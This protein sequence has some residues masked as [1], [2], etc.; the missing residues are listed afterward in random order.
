VK[1]ALLVT[2]KYPQL[3]TVKTRL[4]A[5][6]GEEAALELYECFVDDVLTAARLSGLPTTIFCAPSERLKDFPKRFASHF[7]YAAQHGRDLG[8]RMLQAF[9]HSFAGEAEAALLIG[10]DLPEMRAEVLQSAAQALQEHPAVIV[11]AGDGG[12]CLIGFRREQLV[13]EA[14]HGIPWSTEHV[15]DATLDAMAQKG[16]QPKILDPVP[17]VDTIQDLLL[18]LGREGSRVGAH[19]A[20]WAAAHEEFLMTFKKGGST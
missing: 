14:F 6:I 7:D 11:P 17:D 4:A 18:C 20:A 15:L 9:Q 1:T 2:L 10:G 5:D 13:L 19:T 12:Y 8:E 3:G 16:V